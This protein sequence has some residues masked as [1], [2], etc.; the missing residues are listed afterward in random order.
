DKTTP[1]LAPQQLGHLK[2]RVYTKRFAHLMGHE[3]KNMGIQMNLGPALSLSN[4][5]LD[6][7]ANTK[8]LTAKQERAAIKGLKQS[9]VAV[10]PTD[11]QDDEVIRNKESQ[12]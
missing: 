10:V 2:N 11:F 12:L 5:D 6:S 4:E 9:G 7:Y 3:L 8:D 1:G